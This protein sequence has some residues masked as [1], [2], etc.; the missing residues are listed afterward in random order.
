MEGKAGKARE[1]EG[2]RREEPHRQPPRDKVE[3]EGGSR[4]RA[5]E[6]E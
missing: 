6:Y 5:N 4:E 2:R 1:R 3:K